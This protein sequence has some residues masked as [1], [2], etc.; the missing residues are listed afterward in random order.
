MGGINKL[1]GTH[2]ER[3]LAAKR[4]KKRLGGAP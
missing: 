4:E 1:K 3:I 2:R